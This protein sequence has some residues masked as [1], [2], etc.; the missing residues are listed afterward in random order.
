MSCGSSRIGRIDCVGRVEAPKTRPWGTDPIG[1]VAVAPCRGSFLLHHSTSRNWLGGVDC[2]SHLL[3]QYVRADDIRAIKA[4]FRYVDDFP[5]SGFRFPDITPNFEQDSQGL[6]RIV[7]L[8][9]P[10][11]AEL[12]PDVIVAVDSC[13][14]LFAAPIAYGMACRIAL[15]RREGK[16][17]PPCDAQA[18]EMCYDDQ[19]SIEIHPHAFRPNDRAVI[20]DDILGSGGTAGAVATLVGRQHAVPTA[21][22]C[23]AEIV[24]LKGRSVLSKLALPVHAL[25]QL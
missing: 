23:V 12:K 25:I 9:H 17:A 6:R 7:D 2:D 20:V 18:Y 22:V 21:L 5:R 16:L 15:A 11:V 14:Y 4:A 24:S 8:L 13:G 1:G 19:R 3:E 10:I